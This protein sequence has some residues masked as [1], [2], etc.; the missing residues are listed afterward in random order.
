MRLLR[1]GLSSEEQ[2]RSEVFSKWLLNVGNGEIGEPDEEGIQDRYWITIP[3]EYCRET[4]EIEML[5]PME[6][7]NTMSFPGI[8]PYELQLKVGSPIM[9][10]RNVNLS[11]GLCN[12]TRMIFSKSR[13][14]SETTIA[15]LRIGQEN[16]ILEAKVYQKWISKSVPVMKELAFCCILID[17]QNNA[18]QANLDV[19][20]IDYF[21]PLLKP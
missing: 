16:R 7:H 19:N 15:S 6:Y 2:R 20:N 3:P 11:R 21:N 12:G 18:I 17:K 4:S 13:K 8:P 10:L 9:L 5:Y 14:M 1:P